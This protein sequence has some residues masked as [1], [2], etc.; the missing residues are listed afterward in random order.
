[1]T[2]AE[3]ACRRPP[4]PPR[5]GGTPSRT[6][7]RPRE[8]RWRWARRTPQARRRGGARAGTA[9]DKILKNVLLGNGFKM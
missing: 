7:G 3:L 6:W 8:R 5:A 4:P 2:L 9:G 1:M